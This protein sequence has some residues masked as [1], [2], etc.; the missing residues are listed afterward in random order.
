MRQTTLLLPGLYDSGPDHWQTRW[1]Q[2]DARCRRVVQ[3]DW[4]APRCAD[5]VER[6]DRT[7]HDLDGEAVLVGHS[8]GCLLVAHWAASARAEQLARIRGALLVA[9]S[10]PDGPVY[11]TGPT[12]FAPVP[13][14]SLPF[15]SIVVT[16][17]NDPYVSPVRA[18]QFAAAWGSRCESI[19]QA[20]H[21]NAESALGLWPFGR[22]LLEEVRG[23]EPIAPPPYYHGTRAALQVGDLI[24]PGYASNYGQR[25]RAAWVYLSATLDAATW[26]AE[27]AQGSGRERIY[28]VEPTGLLE[29]DPN[30]TNARFAGNPTRSYRTRESL[31]VVGEVTEW[32]PHAAEQV[33]AMRAHL[34][35]LAEQGIEAIED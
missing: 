9:P 11:P 20:G 7:V 27:L 3:S 16:S 28:V 22:A 8:T 25:R 1:E 29:H 18:T 4:S 17:E 32:T 10:D 5:W 35:R 12:G 34:A 30:L 2:Y 15:A 26:G 6:L 19:G 23:G 33:Q 13:L 24:A 14:A 21:I 31:R